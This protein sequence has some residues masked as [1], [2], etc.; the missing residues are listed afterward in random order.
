MLF[1]QQGRSFLKGQ[2]VSSSEHFTPR[3][4]QGSKELEAVLSDRLQELPPPTRGDSPTLA[5]GREQAQPWFGRKT[6]EQAEVFS[7]CMQLVQFL[8][9]AWAAWLEFKIS[10]GLSRPILS[11]LQN[12]DMPGA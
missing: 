1:V 7:S 3:A 10:S 4:E 11:R 5:Q 8:D 2:V 12:F 9:C 6:S